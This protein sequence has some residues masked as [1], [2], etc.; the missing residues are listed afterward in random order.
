M[1]MIC[2]FI[3]IKNKMKKYMRRIGQKT[4]TSN[5]G[6][7]VI[8][9]LVK[10]P[11]AEANQNLN[12]GKRRANGRNSFPS[13]AVEGKP[14]ESSFGSSRGDKNAIKLLSKKMPRPYATIK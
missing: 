3:V 8:K 10:V 1:C 11:L 14:G 4:G 2:R 12:S 7:N 13:E 9:M 6:K 5:T